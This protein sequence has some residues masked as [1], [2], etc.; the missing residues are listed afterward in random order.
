MKKYIL[1]ILPAVV[2]FSITSCDKSNGPDSPMQGTWYFKSL[3]CYQGPNQNLAFYVYPNSYIKFNA[4]KTGE[5]YNAGASLYNHFSY[6]MLNNDTTFSITSTGNLMSAAQIDT[7]II[8]KLTANEF[9][10]HSIRTGAPPA[11]AVCLNI[12]DSLYR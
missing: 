6:T 3:R 9:I 2:L 12:I 4:D 8:M 11:N 7:M 5:E 10:Y 1:F